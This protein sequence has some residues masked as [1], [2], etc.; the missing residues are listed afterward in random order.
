MTYP[1]VPLTTRLRFVSAPDAEMIPDFFDAL[2]V[3]VQVYGQPVW[4]DKESRWF[5]WFVPGDQSVDIVSTHL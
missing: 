4:L 1:D 2:G 3:R 5:V